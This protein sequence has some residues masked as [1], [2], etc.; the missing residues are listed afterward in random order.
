MPVQFARMI[1]SWLL[2]SGRGALANTLARV[3]GEATPDDR[4]EYGDRRYP[5]SGAGTGWHPPGISVTG[6]YA[7]PE[8]KRVRHEFLAGEHRD[9]FDQLVEQCRASES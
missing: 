3:V 9:A 2:G 5:T 6:Q 4:W 7:V 1:G 8:Y